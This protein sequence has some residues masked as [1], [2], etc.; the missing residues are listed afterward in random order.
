MTALARQLTRAQQ[1]PGTTWYRT[2]ANNG[3]GTAKLKLG[4][5]HLEGE[6]ASQDF[7]LALKLNF[8]SAPL[9]GA[10]VLVD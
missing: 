10:R 1:P 6:G 3:C 4:S 9:K 7:A 5:L 8:L 2:A